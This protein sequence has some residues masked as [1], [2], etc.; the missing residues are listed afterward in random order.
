MWVIY[1]WTIFCIYPIRIHYANPTAQIQNRLV[2]HPDRGAVG[3]A[4]LCRA[5]AGHAGATDGRRHGHLGGGASPAAHHH[6]TYL[7]EI[8]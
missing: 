3:R 8:T 7:G 1:H 5:A 4:G 6:A 2:C